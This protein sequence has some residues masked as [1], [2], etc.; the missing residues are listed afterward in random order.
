MGMNLSSGPHAQS[1]ARLKEIA[2]ALGISVDRFTEG[3]DS[4]FVG[5]VLDLMR[6]YASITDLQGRQRV[7]N[8]VRREAARCEEAHANPDSSP[9]RD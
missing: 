4:P 1:S 7:L 6:L 9:H 8:V 2:D 3:G 5:D